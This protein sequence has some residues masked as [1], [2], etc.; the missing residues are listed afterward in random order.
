M[1]NEISIST[2]RTQ[3]HVIQTYRERIHIFL[4]ERIAIVTPR[5]G[6][7]LS[8]DRSI[9]I[10]TSRI[11]ENEDLKKKKK[12]EEKVEEDWE[13]EIRDLEL[14]WSFFSSS[15]LVGRPFC[16]FSGCCRGGNGRDGVVGPTACCLS[17]TSR[18]I[19]KCKA[20]L[21]LFCVRR[22]RWMESHPF[23]SSFAPVNALRLVWF[24]RGREVEGFY[25][26]FKSNHRWF[27][28]ITNNDFPFKI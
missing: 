26:K 23:S 2:S 4:V 7:S 28:T 20:S 18:W 3:A 17:F 21:R 27:F 5:H 15:S 9:S 1:R 12:E 13:K 14:F 11:E 22:L 24:L 8:R 25:R 6:I 10:S 16:I 19:E